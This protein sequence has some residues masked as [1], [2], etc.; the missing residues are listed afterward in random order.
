MRVLKHNIHNIGIKSSLRVGRPGATTSGPSIIFLQE[1]KYVLITGV[2]RLHEKYFVLLLRCHAKSFRRKLASLGEINLKWCSLRF[3]DATR[4]F[5]L[6]R[7]GSAEYK[8][9][10]L[11]VSQICRQYVCKFLLIILF[12]FFIYQPWWYMYTQDWAANDPI[13]TPP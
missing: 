6:V 9:P 5:G 1:S 2:L 10:N 11:T 8:C 4:I 12:R 3:K 13:D 7:Y